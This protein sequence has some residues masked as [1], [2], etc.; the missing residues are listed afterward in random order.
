MSDKGE[1]Y[2]V[3]LRSHNRFHAIWLSGIYARIKIAKDLLTDDGVI[4][5][6]IDN[7]EISNLKKIADEIFG[8]ESFVT[9][10]HVQM[11]TVQGQK[12][13]AAKTGNI[14]K[15]GEYILMYSKNGDKAIGRKLLLDPVKYDNHYNKILLEKKHGL[16]ECI[17][18]SEVINENRRVCEEL[19]LLGL[20]KA[21][22]ISL[23]NLQD[24]YEVS[25]SFRKYINDR[26]E[27]I[28]RIHDSVDV[29]ETFKD[30]MEVGL[31]Y[32]YSS[33]NRDY[34]V[35]KNSAG[36]IMQCITLSDKIQAANDFYK[37]FGPTTIRGD[38]WAGFYLDM[39]N[40]SK[41]GDVSYD[42]G[43]KPVRLIK[44]LVD[45]CTE[46]DD[47]ILDFY[48]GSATTAHAVMELEA[49]SEEKRKFIMIQVNEDL[50]R[51]LELADADN[52]KTIKNAISFLDDINKP[53]ILSEIGKERIRRS[54][55]KIKSEYQDVE[56]DIGFKVFRA[57]A[58]NIKW[59]SL[60]DVGQLDI[61][62]IE[63]DPDSLDFMP[64]TKDIDVVYEIMLRQRDV[65]LS[66]SVELLSDIGSRTYL[67]ASSFLV[68]LETE[69]TEALVE[70][71][72][73]IDPLPIKFI[74]RDSAF[75]DDIALKDETFR[76]LRALVE[77][78]SGESKPTYTVEFI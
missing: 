46:N 14:V 9:C 17:N 34:L 35:T 61:A 53:H 25:P 4:A 1:K 11:S 29:P 51:S 10:L 78:N 3:N 65:A 12:V 49:E 60:M 45:L 7:N 39:G 52:K 41:E 64:N 59:N 31:V 38:W 5:I 22:K 33:E 37:T 56:L 16:Y 8:E 57:E 77:R 58:T 55:E 50:D 47:I 18:L 69:I 54:G 28:V 75:K 42:N 66:E 15:N 36:K 20:C 68:C 6:S 74:F 32:E 63:S 76:K 48:S 71:I 73:A 30:R 13:K 43:K 70:K 24:Y 72:A 62:Q 23:S 2:S 19:E 44:Q 40:V 26:A 27:M 21:G 67:Y